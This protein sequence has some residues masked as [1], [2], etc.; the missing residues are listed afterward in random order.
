MHVIVDRVDVNVHGCG[1]E[2][3]VKKFFSVV[4]LSVC[5]T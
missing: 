4:K 3:V 2:Y 5:Y 1:S